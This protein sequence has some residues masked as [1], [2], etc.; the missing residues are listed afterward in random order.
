L[1]VLNI[2]LSAGIL[3]PRVF[4]MFVLEA[5]ILTFMTMPL[6]SLLYPP[7]RRI[8]VTAGGIAPSPNGEDFEDQC[9]PKFFITNDPAWR[10]RFT[11]VLDKF[12]HMSGMLV[13]TQLVCP[14]PAESAVRSTESTSSDKIKTPE[15]SVNALRLIELSDRTSDVMKSSAVDT[16]IHTDRVLGVFRTFGELNDLPVSLSLSIVPFEDMSYTVADHAKRHGSQLLLLPWLP[17]SI[18]SGDPNEDLSGAHNAK[19]DLNPFEAF[20]GGSKSTKSA[21]AIH[22]QFVRRVF[23]ESKTDVALF[24]D[25]GASHSVGA[26]TGT[27]SARHI[28]FPFFGGPDDRLAL[29]FVVQLCANPRMSATVVRMSKSGVEGADIERPSLAHLDEKTSLEPPSVGILS[30]RRTTSRFCIPDSRSSL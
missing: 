4:S 3:T 29:E 21:A 8:R 27:G 1:I 16:L 10:N 7:E 17:P 13:A 26:G 11:V 22:S 12:D 28:F 15:V 2:G 14:N 23:A 9:D 18:T 24:I 20:F 25:P 19:V 5:L 30:L 6:V